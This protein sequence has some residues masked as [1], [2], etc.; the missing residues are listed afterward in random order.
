M[1]DG[2]WMYHVGYSETWTEG[3]YFNTEEEAIKEGREY[4]KEEGYEQYETGQIQIFIPCVNVSSVLD[5]IRED[6]YERCG[7]AGEDYFDDV[8]RDHES[9][10]EDR[11]NEV[12]IQWMEEHKL[13]TQYFNLDNIKD[14][15]I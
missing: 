9:E 2:Q 1:K 13:N 14:H 7:E 10:L 8:T 12:L 11:F 5:N 15:S 4:A 3:E 6:A